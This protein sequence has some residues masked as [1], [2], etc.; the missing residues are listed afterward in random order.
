MRATSLLIDERPLQKIR[1]MKESF[2]SLFI[3]IIEE[4]LD[5]SSGTTV[6]VSADKRWRDINA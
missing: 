3:R 4:K 2:G 5:Y 1:R 6:F